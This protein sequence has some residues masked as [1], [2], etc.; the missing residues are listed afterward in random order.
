MIE[1]P[2]ST[3]LWNF[4]S[5]IVG[6]YFVDIPY[7]VVILDLLKIDGEH[8]TNEVYNFTQMTR[9]TSFLTFCTKNSC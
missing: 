8:N 4:S 3:I 9:V 5:N 7:I 1:F 6:N 2:C